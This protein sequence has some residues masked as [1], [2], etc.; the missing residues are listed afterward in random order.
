[1]SELNDPKATLLR[2]LD[3]NREALLW[4]L[5]GLS[6]HDVRRPLTPTGTNLLGLVKHVALVEFGYLGETSDRT[7]QSS[8]PWSEAAYA[9][10]ET[11]PNSTC[12]PRLSSPATRSCCCT[13]RRA[14]T[15]PRP[16]RSS[17]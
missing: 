17:P 7:P 12:T 8:V 6:D 13:A 11:V 10:T 14:P 1:M 15:A 9:A 2:Y 3:A 16:S 4:K 5:D